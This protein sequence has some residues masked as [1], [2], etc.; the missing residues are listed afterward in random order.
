MVARGYL[1][2]LARSPPKI[3]C[4][5]YISYPISFVITFLKIDF[6]LDKEFAIMI[7]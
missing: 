4:L 5:N 1:Y 6:E 7:S 3:I 2:L